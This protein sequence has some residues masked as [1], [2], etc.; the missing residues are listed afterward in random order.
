M[1]YDMNNTNCQ[2]LPVTVTKRP[3]YWSLNPDDNKNT[4]TTHLWFHR[5]PL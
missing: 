4:L 2:I 3:N 1:K 5:I